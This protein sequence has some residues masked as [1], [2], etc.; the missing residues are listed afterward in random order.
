[1]VFVGKRRATPDSPT[2]RRVAES[3]FK[4]SC[5]KRTETEDEAHVGTEKQK[6]NMRG[7][8]RRGKEN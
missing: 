6:N 1:M 8:G 7:E 3:K 5:D 2:P 4:K